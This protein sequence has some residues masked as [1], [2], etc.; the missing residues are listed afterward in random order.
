MPDRPLLGERH[1]STC[2]VGCERSTAVRSDGRSVCTLCF[3][4]FVTPLLIYVLVERGY[5]KKPLKPKLVNSSCIGAKGHVHDYRVQCQA[6]SLSIRGKERKE[7]GGRIRN[8]YDRT[9]RHRHIPK[10]EL[11][12]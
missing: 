11:K 4:S 5:I 7:I 6:P 2:Y 9:V 3:V 12:R 1:N 10:L 8:L